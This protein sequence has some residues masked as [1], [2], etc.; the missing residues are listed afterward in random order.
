MSLPPN[1]WSYYV[2]SLL[3]SSC[4]TK[5]GH[6]RLYY[7]V[8][9]ERFEGKKRVPQKLLTYLAKICC[10]C[11]CISSFSHLI[12]S[13]KMSSTYKVIFWIP[14]YKNVYSFSIMAILSWFHQFLICCSLWTNQNM[15]LL[16]YEGNPH[17]KK[18]FLCSFIH[19][20]I[21]SCRQRTIP[22]C[23]MSLW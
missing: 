19:G 2:N 4:M 11:T 6:W 5:S 8:R 13:L 1:T 14:C 20:S 3:L 23:F 17:S 12:N 21:L 22:T 15:K 7:I 18:L 9:M 16:I 10:M